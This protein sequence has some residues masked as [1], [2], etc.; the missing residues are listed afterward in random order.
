MSA[1]ETSVLVILLR[2]QGR[3]VPK[4]NV[5]DHIFGLEGEV[6]SN[7]VEVYISRLRRQLAKYGAEVVIHTIRGVNRLPEPSRLPEPVRS[8]ITPRQPEPSRHF[9]LS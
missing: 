4:T 5:E 8:A 2:R 1:R 9:E 7:A 3:V 6:A